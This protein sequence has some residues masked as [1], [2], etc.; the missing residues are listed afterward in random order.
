MNYLKN[1]CLLFSAFLLIASCQKD[2]EENPG[3]KETPFRFI[4]EQYQ[5]FNYIT[6]DSAAA[7]LAPELLA[8]ICE[9]LNIECEIEF[10]PWET[11]YE[12]A[13]NNENAVLFSTAL[14]ASRKDKFKWAGPFASLDWNFYAASQTE[15]FL[16]NIDDAKSVGSIGVISD[17]AM[18]DFLLEEGFENL[19]Y[20]TDIS[21]A[22]TRLLNGE[23]D[24]FPS[25]K[26]TTEAA[27][28]SMGHTLYAVTSKLI[29]KTEFLYF[30]FNKNISDDMVAGFQTAIDL[31][32]KNGTLRQL[33]EKH[34]KT[35][36]FPDILQVYTEPYPPLTFRGKNGEITG[37]GTDI[38]K[39]IMKRNSEF[40][41]ITLSSWS[42]GYQLA[43]NNPNVCLYTMDRT[44]I[45]EDLFL[46]VGPIG[47]NT[48]FF[49]TKAGSGITILSI[50]DA[51]NLDNVGT[52]SSWFST[53][54]LQEL[55]FTNLVQDSDP[56]VLVEKMLNGELDAFVCTD[57][58]FPDILS[59]AGYQY[60]DVNPS[61]ELMASDFFIAFSK[62][63][64]AET[65]EKWQTALSNLKQDGT[66]NAIQQ[67][68]FPQ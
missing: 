53:Q 10:L 43:L 14:N 6:E 63:T 2:P 58:T 11:G 31:A 15:I 59:E 12:E 55:G 65:I 62:N 28:E 5:P 35:S 38:V 45:R 23:I 9:Q 13:L 17:Y 22:L 18:E 21:D 20:C 16:D 46:W 36:D 29:I 66:Y 24:L 50:E 30:A 7:G 25:D 39:E 37:Y 68:W 56:E 32:K 48:T 34:L 49:Y 67:K 64:S 40:F 26:Y 3:N 44:E 42:N 57:I 1:I 19:V 4:S 61:L 54:H 41:E 52:V 33:T 47:T 51:K 8:G 60:S 27:L